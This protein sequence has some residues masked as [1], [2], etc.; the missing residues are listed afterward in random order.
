MN[1]ASMKPSSSYYWNKSSRRIM[2]CRRKLRNH[3]ERRSVISIFI[4]VKCSRN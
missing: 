3:V 1:V 2:N 4:R